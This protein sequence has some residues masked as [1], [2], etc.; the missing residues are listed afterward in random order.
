L[1]DDGGGH[2]GPVHV[3]DAS[4]VVLQPGEQARLVAP[5]QEAAVDLVR[6]A[7][8]GDLA[9]LLGLV[10]G[11]LGLRLADRPLLVGPG[12][13]GLGRPPRQQPVGLHLRHEAIEVV[14]VLRL[15]VLAQLVLDRRADVTV[16]RH[17][18]VALVHRISRSG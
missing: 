6:V 11:E 2:A 16:G 14:E 15:A 17:D 3:G 13:A 4:R 8:A 1:E 10:L 18:D 7:D 5:L 9:E 12:L